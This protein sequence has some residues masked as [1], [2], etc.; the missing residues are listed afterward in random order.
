MEELI[1]ITI[2]DKRPEP[3]M[4]EFDGWL[5]KPAQ[6]CANELY[7]AGIPEELADKVGSGLRTGPVMT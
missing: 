5:L 1:G 3:R 2:T 6:K 4:P 7:D